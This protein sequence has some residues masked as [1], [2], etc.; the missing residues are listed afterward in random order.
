MK[1]IRLSILGSKT[2]IYSSRSLSFNF[3]LRW[4][5]ISPK[6]KGQI[7]LSSN[8]VAEM[9]LP[10]SRLDNQNVHRLLKPVHLP[11]PALPKRISLIFLW[12]ELSWRDPITIVNPLQYK[13]CIFWRTM[14]CKLLFG[15]AVILHNW[16]QYFPPLLV[17]T[18]LQ[19]YDKLEVFWENKW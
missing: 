16:F 4:H 9:Y 14:G 18:R 12:E 5:T 19:H 17:L 1:Y 8:S 3:V 15:L 2:L 11:T 10:A 7:L 6:G 13:V